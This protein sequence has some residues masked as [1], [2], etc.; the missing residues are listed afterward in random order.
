MSH[1]SQPPASFVS[2]TSVMSG[3]GDA[4]SAVASLQAAAAGPSVIAKG[5]S[6]TATPVAQCTRQ[7][8]SGYAAAAWGTTA[9]ISVGPTTTN[10]AGWLPSDTAVTWSRL[11][12]VRVTVS[13]TGPEAGLKE[14]SVGTAGVTSNGTA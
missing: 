12:P 5:V 13:P 3:A 2:A 14:A 11:V 10:D 7:R 4:S 9:W 6:W 8:T 1:C